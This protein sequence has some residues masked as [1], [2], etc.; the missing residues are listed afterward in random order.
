MLLTCTVCF[1]AAG[2]R[3]PELVSGSL[4]RLMFLP[5]DAEIILN[6]VQDSMTNA[7]HSLMRFGFHGSRKIFF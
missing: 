4:A 1:Y 6:Q 5:G 7:T 3:H 2:I